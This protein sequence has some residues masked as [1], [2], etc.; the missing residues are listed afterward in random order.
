VENQEAETVRSYSAHGL[1]SWPV[2]RF[3][4]PS[5]R[6]R[7]ADV[8]DADEHRDVVLCRRIQQRR[9][10]SS[11]HDHVCGL[12]KGHR[13]EKHQCNRCRPGKRYRW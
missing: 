4:K 1:G 12:V 8:P 3:A 7:A 6:N 2:R 5:K 13:G 10:I 11:D 9:R